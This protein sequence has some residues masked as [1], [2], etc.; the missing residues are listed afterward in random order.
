V[1]A[2]ALKWIGISVGLLALLGLVLWTVHDLEAKGAAH[3]REATAAATVAQ[4]KK[5][6]EETARLQQQQSKALYDA[7]LREDRL[8]ADRDRSNRARDDVRVQLDAYVRAH[9]RPADPAASGAVPAVDGGD[10]IGVLADM[11][12]RSDAF[13][14]VVVDVAD[15]RG[16]RALGCEQSYP[17]IPAT[18]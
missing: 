15:K 17:V 12:R 16:E 14:D 18:P 3:E 13:A 6:A 2:L 10:P 7:Q 9:S 5:D 11:L 8:R 4:Q 1:S